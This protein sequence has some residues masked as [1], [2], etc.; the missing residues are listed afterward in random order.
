MILQ[1]QS[2]LGNLKEL[3]S[4]PK[5][6]TDDFWVSMFG[7]F[8]GYLSNI[9]YYSYAIDFTEINSMMKAGPSINNCIDTGEIPPYLDDN[10]WFSTD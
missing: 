1:L 8:E 6:N 3:S 4:L 5:Q 9:R 2:F 10:W 7:G